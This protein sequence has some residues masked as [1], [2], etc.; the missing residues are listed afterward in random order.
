MYGYLGI[1]S[2]TLANRR[3]VNSFPFFL[4]ADVCTIFARLDLGIMPE[5]LD[6]C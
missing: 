2:C 6:D 3:S 1:H 5:A 4:V